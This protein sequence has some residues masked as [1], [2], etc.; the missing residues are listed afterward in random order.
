M[1]KP[2]SIAQAQEPTVA[3]VRLRTRPPSSRTVILA[4]SATAAAVDSDAVTT[5]S[6]R[7]AGSSAA[8]SCGV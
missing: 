2:E 1:T 3:M 7:S 6:G 4:E 5:V 8:R